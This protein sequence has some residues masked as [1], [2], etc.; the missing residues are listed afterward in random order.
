MRTTSARWAYVFALVLVAGL[1]AAPARAQDESVRDPLTL[2]QQLLG[3][4]GDVPVPPPLP[5]YRP[6]DTETFWVSKA[7]QDYPTQISAGLAAAA[8]GIYLWV[9]QG[10]AYDADAMQELAA[11]LNGLLAL[12]QIRDNYG[13]IRVVPDT[14]AAFNARSRF[15]LPDVDNDPHLS[16]LYAAGLRD[17]RNA[18]FN[19]N[20]SL[21]AELAPGGYS[22]Q[23]ELIVVNTSAAPGV[24]LHADVY[25]GILARQFYHMLAHY[26]R[27]T[28]AAWLDN[29][30][31]WYMLRQLQGAALTSSDIAAFLNAPDTGL[32]QNAN[33]G[34]VFG[35]Q[36]LFLQYAAQRLGQ[37][38][39]DALFDEP[40][41]GLSALDAVLSR[42]GFTDMVTGEALTAEA[43]FADF[44]MANI[45]NGFVGDGRFM[46][47]NLNFGEAQAAASLLQD[48]P[49]ADL[50]GSSV[51]QLGTRYLIVAYSN[52]AAVEVTF[53]GQPAVSRLPMPGAEDNQFYW[54]GAGL[55]RAAWLTRAFDLRETR[56]ATLA[57]DAWYM[58]ADG[59]NYGYVQVS[60]DGGQTWESLATTGTQ[61]ANPYGAAYGP[62]YTGISSPQLPRPFPYLG[63]GLDADGLTITEILPGGPAT[64]SDLQP[65]DTIAGYDGQPWPGRPDL[66]G[67]LATH[68]AGDTV[69]LY[70][71]RGQTF[72]DAP[73]TLGEHPTRVLLPDAVWMREQADLSAY[74]GQ[75]ILLRFGCISLPGRDNPGFAVDNIAVP[76]VGFYDDA[77]RGV[78]GWTLDGWRQ[79]GSQTRQKFLL[80]VAIIG[81]SA[82]TS[83]VRRLIGPGD[84]ATGG[85]WSFPLAAGEFMVIAVSGLNDDTAQ[86]ARF[87]LR[88]RSDTA[89]APAAASN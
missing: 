70:I 67:W 42:R 74:A 62:G 77:E 82:E 8:P 33:T 35:A 2:A 30:L 41:E 18:Y 1:L 61:T 15:M 9:E 26:N 66:L 53:D 27:P 46:Y 7:G 29:A 6:G 24:P 55:N 87:D 68:E 76:E 54:S 57:F 36:Q 48:T 21:V 16:I 10:L 31:G 58:L 59:W 60:A 83:R 88:V 75:E 79:T 3:F 80:Q 64:T 19:P 20:D 40:G 43:V 45:L 44:A 4:S 5:L 17:P 84:T 65:G 13:Q 28:L 25:A 52:P 81:D 86:P 22:N 38:A 50:S 56:Q 71:R 14:L 39:L 47:P 63:I 69:S 85:V 37:G 23:R 72:L 12:L 78:P 11:N 34:T 73:V 51:G 32:T 89:G 49:E